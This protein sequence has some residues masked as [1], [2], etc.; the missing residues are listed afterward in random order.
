MVILGV[1]ASLFNSRHES[2]TGGINDPA[3]EAIPGIV[4]NII[5]A[6]AVYGFFTVF[7]AAQVVLAK[8]DSRHALFAPRAPSRYRPAT[9]FI[10]NIATDPIIT[11]ATATPTTT[12]IANPRT[13]PASGNTYALVTVIAAAG[14]LRLFWSS[15]T[16]AG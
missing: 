4:S 9:A 2:F 10:I 12:P 13:A 7:C 16:G 1:I 5:A 14:S 11:T 6:V 3:P 15:L 8:R